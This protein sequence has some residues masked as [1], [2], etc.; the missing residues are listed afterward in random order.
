MAG[1]KKFEEIVAWQKARKTAKL[2]YKVS[3][4]D[5]FTKDYGLR[6][7]IRRSCVSIMGNIAE[8]QGRYSNKE[9]AN[10]LNIAHGSIAETQSHLYI[11]L[12]LDYINQTDFEEIYNLLDEVAKMTMSLTKHLRK[13]QVEN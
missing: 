5:K 13:P 11:A 12:D 3:L 2:V 8:G 4:S 1:F 9:F 7:Q 6:D 10:F